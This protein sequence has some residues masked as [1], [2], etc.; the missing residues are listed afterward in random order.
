MYSSNISELNFFHFPVCEG[1]F[2]VLGNV[3][4]RELE[5]LKRVGYIGQSVT[6]LVTYMAPSTPGQCDSVLIAQLANLPSL[7]APFILN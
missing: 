5:A 2:L 7:L 6:H 3:E 1:W 4:N